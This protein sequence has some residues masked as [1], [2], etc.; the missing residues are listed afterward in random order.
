MPY[1]F[2]EREYELETQASSSR[3]GHPPRKIT[4]VGILDPS[5]PSKRHDPLLPLPISAPV[6]LRFVAGII[7]VGILVGMVVVAFLPLLARH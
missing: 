2:T 3:G 6:F 7:L 1:E 4:G 5:V